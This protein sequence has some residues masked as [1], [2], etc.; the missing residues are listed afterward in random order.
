MRRPRKTWRRPDAPALM[1]RDRDWLMVKRR[2]TGAAVPAELQEL[3]EYLMLRIAEGRA[4]LARLDAV[5]QSRP[6]R[7]G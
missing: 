4:R 3:S 1:P 7:R 5:L 6:R 2:L